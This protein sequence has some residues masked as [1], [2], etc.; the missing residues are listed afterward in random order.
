MGERVG[1]DEV[2]APQHADVELPD[3][4]L[5]GRRRHFCWWERGEL[6]DWGDKSRAEAPTRGGGRVVC[7]LVDAANGGR[8]PPGFIGAAACQR[9]PSAPASWTILLPIVVSCMLTGY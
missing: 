7:S 3:H 5:L 6:R 1:D 8:P 4:L 9:G 2:V